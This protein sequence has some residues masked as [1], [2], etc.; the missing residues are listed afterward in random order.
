MALTE[1]EAGLHE[2]RRVRGVI[3]AVPV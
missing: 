3:V 2:V 1:V